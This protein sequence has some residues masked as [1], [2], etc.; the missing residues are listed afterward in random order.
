MFRD[1]DIEKR[2]FWEYLLNIFFHHDKDISQEAE[3]ANEGPVEL[4]IISTYVKS[5]A[6]FFPASR[7][8]DC[9]DGFPWGELK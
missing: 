2:P 8:Y 5:T 7:L 1:S 6:D 4:G 3:R 9:E